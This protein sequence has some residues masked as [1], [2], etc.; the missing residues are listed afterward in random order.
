MKFLVEIPD[1][2][3]SVF[4]DKEDRRQEVWSVLDEVFSQVIVEVVNEKH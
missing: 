4:E 2:A 3:F 1:Y